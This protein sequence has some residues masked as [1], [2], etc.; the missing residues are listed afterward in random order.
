MEG[1][2]RQMEEYATGKK[3]KNYLEGGEGKVTDAEL[4]NQ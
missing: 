1:T 4:Q 2:T 3:V